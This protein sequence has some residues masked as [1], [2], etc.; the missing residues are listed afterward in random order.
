MGIDP[1]YQ[2]LIAFAAARPR[3]YERSV[4]LRALLGYAYLIAALLAVVG[5]AIGLGLF[6]IW[7]GSLGH[8]TGFFA[9]LWMALGGLALSIAHAFTIT[10]PDPKGTSLV[11]QDAP[12][13]F[14]L[15]DELVANARAT[16]VNEVLLVD[17]M[18]AACVQ[19]RRFGLVGPTRRY[20]LIGVTALLATTPDEFRA[21][22]AHE[23]GHLSTQHGR[24][25]AW[26]YGVR[27]TW[28]RFFASLHERR[29]LLAGL[30]ERLISGYLT[31]FFRYSFV[32]ARQQEI[33]ADRFG[34]A[35]CGA[36]TMGDALVRLA[37]A[38]RV[39][40]RS[41]DVDVG[42]VALHD[43]GPAARARILL[44]SELA[45]SQRDRDLSAVLAEPAGFGD[46]H[47]ALAERLRVLGVAGRV[48]EMAAPSAAERY[49]GARAA[50]L[51]ARVDEARRAVVRES[52]IGSAPTDDL[53]ALKSELA[54]LE[55]AVLDEMSTDQLRGRAQ[56]TDVLHGSKA[57]FH[58]YSALAARDDALGHF[59]VGRL[60]L[61]S[62]DESGLSSLD[63]VIEL[64]KDLAFAAAS[65]A[66]DFLSNDG[67][68]EEAGRYRAIAEE[69]QAELEATF[70]V[71]TSLATTD[72]LTQHDLPG[73]LV[74]GIAATLARV[75]PVSRAFMVKKLTK[76]RPELRAYFLAVAYDTAWFLRTEQEDVDTMT[77]R[78][79][80]GIAAL[81]PD[82]TVVV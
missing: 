23:I 19:V 51:L 57:A 81:S 2:R 7:W 5:M 48:L 14:R 43:L 25:H 60:R 69:R 40:A 55:T 41:A 72:D 59:G 47:P 12:D 26:A 9:F 16:D 54:K 6:L 71:R 38:A 35:L 29:S 21:I 74:T 49:L 50:E 20:L 32:L 45:A 4:V 76:D 3:E 70:H 79:Q 28:L 62:G 78:L 66:A 27:E 31:E 33:E 64:D 61:A 63:R 10:P 42:I 36:G 46:P 1:E 39:M 8:P 68:V 24:T 22:L 15:I 75:K 17:E 65:I 53:A 34:G 13:L 30:F 11:R 58:D 67:R 73:D 56:L 44:A 82:I 37:T 18:D 77:G 52:D 80:E